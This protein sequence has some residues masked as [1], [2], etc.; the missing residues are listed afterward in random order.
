MNNSAAAAAIG[1]MASAAAWP[2]SVTA[3]CALL[4]GR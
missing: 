1:E 4:H 3:A 2:Q